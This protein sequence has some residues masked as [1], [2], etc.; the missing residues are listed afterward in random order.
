MLACQHPRGATL[1]PACLHLLR[2]AAHAGISAGSCWTAPQ[3]VSSHSKLRPTVTHCCATARALCWHQAQRGPHPSRPSRQVYQSPLH[4]ASV[5]SLCW[6]PYELG[7]VLAAASS[8]GSLSVLTYQPDGSWHADKV[9]GMPCLPPCARGS[10]RLA[11]QCMPCQAIGAAC[12]HA[13]CSVPCPCTLPS[14]PCLCSRGC[15]H[16]LPPPPHVPCPADRRRAPRRLHRRQLGARCAQGLAGGLQ[17]ARPAGAAARFVRRR[18]LR[19]GGVGAHAGRWRCPPAW[20][21]AR[22]GLVPGCAC[23]SG[24]RRGSS[25]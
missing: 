11:W 14:P 19:E 24:W 3:A 10:R 7:L 20:R 12:L 4:S 22:R 1:A 17:G 25:S 9:G 13:L 6:A 18:Q 5:N 16:P 8:D 23:W 21:E 2:S 15:S